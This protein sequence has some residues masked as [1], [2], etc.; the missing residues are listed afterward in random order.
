MIDTL[1]EIFEVDC[2][3]VDRSAIRCDRPPNEKRL[4]LYV[5]HFFRPFIYASSS[6]NE[7]DTGCLIDHFSID[8]SVD[9]RGDIFE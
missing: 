9:L 4:D 3:M 8:I 5:I 1:Q 7:E 6:S 2:L